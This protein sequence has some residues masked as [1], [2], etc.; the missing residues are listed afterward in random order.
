[1]AMNTQPTGDSTTTRWRPNR[2]NRYISDKT[3]ASATTTTVTYP[4]RDHRVVRHYL[5]SA[6]YPQRVIEELLTENEAREHCLSI[7]ACS[8]T[9]TSKAGKRRTRR[10]GHWFDTFEQ[11]R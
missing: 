7:E 1:M 8:M 10:L 2:T 6:A 4:K 5:G 9:C 11:Y 3:T